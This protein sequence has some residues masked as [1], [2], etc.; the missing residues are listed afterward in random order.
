LADSRSRNRSLNGPGCSF[1]TCSA[2]FDLAPERAQGRHPAVRVCSSVLRRGGARIGYPANN[3]SARAGFRSS[4][5]LSSKAIPRR[6]GPGR[7]KGGKPRPNV[8]WATFPHSSPAVSG[9][10]A[11]GKSLPRMPCT[12]TSPAT[13][14]TFSWPTLPSN[15]YRWGSR[16]AQNVRALER[17]VMAAMG[18]VQ[19]F[20]HFC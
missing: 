12:F 14:I 13:P 17:L 5:L 2:D 11:S 6:T 20:S 1:D 19:S 4:S 15:T 18:S 7:L 9:E 10:Y 8:R 3:S 16:A